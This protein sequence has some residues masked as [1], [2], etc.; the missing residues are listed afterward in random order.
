MGSFPSF[1]LQSTCSEYSVA[2]LPLPPALRLLISRDGCE[3]DDEDNNTFIPQFFL[4]GIHGTQLS[5]REWRRYK[6]FRDTWK[7]YIYKFVCLFL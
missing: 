5:Q 6:G 3:G 2:H 4:L 7:L 1:V